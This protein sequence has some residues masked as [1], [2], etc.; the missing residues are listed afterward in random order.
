MDSSYR[1]V[2][3]HQHDGVQQFL[4]TRLVRIALRGFA[5]RLNPF[6]M[7]DSQVIV[8][9]LAKLGIGVNLVGRGYFVRRRS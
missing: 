6:G 4:E 2:R 8:N 1:C 9:L 7:L 5:I 3:F